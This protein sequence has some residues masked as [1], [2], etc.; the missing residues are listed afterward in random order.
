MCGLLGD[1][2][3]EALSWVDNLG[4]GV[5]GIDLKEGTNPDSRLQEG[6]CLMLLP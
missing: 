1:S 3:L 6:R 5:P 2:K 4:Q